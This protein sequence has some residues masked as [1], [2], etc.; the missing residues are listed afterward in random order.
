MIVGIAVT[1]A[2]FGTQIYLD[3]I[4]RKTSYQAAAQALGNVTV[5]TP[6]PEKVPPGRSTITHEPR[7]R[8]SPT[9]MATPSPRP[10]ALS[11]SES[12]A[13]YRNAL[14]WAAVLIPCLCFLTWETIRRWRRNPVLERRRAL[15]PPFSWQL[16]VQAPPV[17]DY[18]SPRLSGVARKLRRRQFSEIQ[19]LDIAL[20]VASTMQ[21]LGYP[22]FRFRPDTR[23]PE[24]LVLIER[25]SPGDHQAA[26]FD[27]LARVLEQE[28]LFINRFFFESDPRV[29]WSDS[30]SARFSLGELEK[31]FPG[32]RLLIFSDTEMLLDPVSGELASWTT[33][34]LGWPDR[35]VL[36]AAAPA[37]WG[38]AERKVGAQFVVLPATLDGLDQLAERFDTDLRRDLG[39]IIAPTTDARPESD[40]ELEIEKLRRYLGESVFQWLCACAVYPELRW[41]LTVYLGSL[42]AIGENLV[43]ERNLLK[44]IQLP[45]FRTGSIPDPVRLRL[46][47]S[48]G[49]ANEQAAR[50][51]IIDLLERSAAP[52]RGSYAYREW[53]LTFLSQIALQHRRQPKRLK[54][55][56]CEIPPAETARDYVLLRLAEKAPASKVSLIL[57]RFLRTL[58]FENGVPLFGLTTAMRALVTLAMIGIAWWSIDKA[59]TIRPDRAQPSPTATARTSPT[60]TAQPFPTATAQPSPPAAAQP[61]PTATAQP[62]IKAA[63]QPSPAATA[64][65]SPTVV[66]RQSA[67]V[68]KTAYNGGQPTNPRDLRGK[69]ANLYDIPKLIGIGYFEATAK[70]IAEGCAELT[71]N[72]LPTFVTTDGPTEGDIQKQIE[73]I[74]NAISRGVDGIFFAAND[75]VAIS[76]V[77]RKA[78]R[79][80]IRVIGYDAESQPDAREWFLQV[81]TPDAIAK[82]LVDD[83]VSQ[84]GREAD[85]AIVTSSMTAAGQN[86]WIAEIKKYI[87]SAYPKLNLVTILPAEEDQQLAFKITGQILKAYPSVK[88]IIALSSVAFPGAADAITQANLIGKIAVV[89]LSTPNQMRPFVKNGAVKNVILWD[90]IAL[91]YASAYAMRA[92]IDGNLKPGDTEVDAGRL[93][94]LK[95]INGSQILLGPP[96]VFTK[97]NI[98]KYDF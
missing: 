82:A 37:Q 31:R 79:A 62:S 93:G 86:A 18:S 16:E 40:G 39:T 59:A 87:A 94:K 60:A 97:D 91:G 24:Y 25:A 98:D 19:R 75:P 48:L 38:F 96:R 56:L 45:W 63:A 27:Q 54:S 1:T 17:S 22:R 65:L 73:F 57:P 74:D 33:S 23:F 14:H 78:L 11:F 5:S 51:A 68:A 95:V 66:A 36:T 6:A 64:K 28:H 80:G 3:I 49:V 50:E 44:L 92:V 70:G 72:G 9:A 13:E 89:G 12:L 85:F 84:I 47:E 34:L 32:H 10:F 58:A 71:K 26:L 55:T 41:E 42:P 30:G 46:I 35:A 90:P 52:N 61:S 43:T 7:T 77:L 2:I 4:N 76:P 88:G 15:G 20:T 53:N 81:T 29:C 8:A 83:I 69:K 67:A 21:A